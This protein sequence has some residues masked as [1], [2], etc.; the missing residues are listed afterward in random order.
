VQE[1]VIA[2]PKEKEIIEEEFRDESPTTPVT[3]N[4]DQVMD[5]MMSML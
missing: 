1:E 4:S 5:P 2:Q 3:L